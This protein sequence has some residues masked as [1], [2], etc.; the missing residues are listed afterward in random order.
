MGFSQKA[1]YA[2]QQIRKGFETLTQLQINEEDDVITYY[3]RDWDN[4]AN[5]ELELSIAFFKLVAHAVGNNEEV[6]FD[7][8]ASDLACDHLLIDS[9]DGDNE[10]V[11]RYD[12]M[13]WNLLDRQ[14]LE[15][16]PKDFD[17]FIERI[18]KRIEE[19]MEPNQ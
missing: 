10:D 11:S 5:E 16:H 2:I 8:T 19:L 6:L 12:T 4:E 7:G 14:I 15:T 17:A 13:F 9:T 1:L 18:K 3:I